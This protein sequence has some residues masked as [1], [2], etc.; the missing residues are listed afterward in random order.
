MAKVIP[1]GIHTNMQ[2]VAEGVGKNASLSP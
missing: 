2:K 1:I